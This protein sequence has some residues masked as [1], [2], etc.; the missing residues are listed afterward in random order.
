MLLCSSGHW[1]VLDTNTSALNKLTVVGVLEIPDTLSGLSSRL[2]RATPEY[3]SVVLDAVYI[4]I[5]VGAGTKTP[6]R[7]RSLG[8]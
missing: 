2:A 7:P 4:S 6:G 5:Q 8:L 3:R 1:V